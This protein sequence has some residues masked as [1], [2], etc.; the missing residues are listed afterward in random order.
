MEDE[1]LRNRAVVLEQEIGD[2]ER[3]IRVLRDE[4]RVLEREL[5]ELHHLLHEKDRRCPYC[6]Q[7][8]PDTVMEELINTKEK[9]IDE[10]FRTLD[11]LTKKAQELHNELIRIEEMIQKSGGG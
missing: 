6:N 11:E 7:I 10:T 8:I 3:Q 9:E 4:L 5:V 2:T 1:D